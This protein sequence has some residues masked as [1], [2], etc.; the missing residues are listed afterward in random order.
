M[1][2]VMAVVY[3]AFLTRFLPVLAGWVAGHGA[4]LGEGSATLLR[5]GL[6][7]LGVGAL[8]SGLRDAAA[9]RGVEWAAWPWSQSTGGDRRPPIG[10]PPTPAWV[11]TG[12]VPHRRRHRVVF[13]LA[14]CYNIGLGLFSVARPQ[15]LF[16]VAG[17]PPA[18]H[19][20]IFAALAMVIGL[21]GVLYLAVAAYP[22]H[23]WLF[24]AVG[25]SGKVLGPVGLATLV[26]K[27]VWPP[28]AAVIC[29]TNDV[30]WWIPFAQ[31]LRDARPTGTSLGGRRSHSDTT[32]CNAA[33]PR[34]FSGS[35]LPD[36]ERQ[37]GR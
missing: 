8:L 5:V 6:T 4:I 9:A 18:N 33:S 31:Y 16:D 14:G 23:G 37:S 27:G 1:H 7:A 35:A 30:V 15:W 19:P 29:L 25:L 32:Y 17:M 10:A 11:T 12:W 28:A 34:R 20:Q 3:G 36:Y 2:G 22:E 24:A 21:Y 13:G 26:V